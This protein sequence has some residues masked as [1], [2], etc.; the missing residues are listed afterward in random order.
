MSNVVKRAAI[1]AKQA[2]RD[3]KRKYTLEPY[4]HHPQAVAA[5][6]A[7]EGFDDGAVVAAWLHDVIEDCGVTR[8]T[9]RMIF[10]ERV[11][12]MVWA[13]TDQSK[14]EDGTRAERKAIDRAHIANASP[15]AK[16]IK[17]ADLIDNTRS[18][19]KH[20]P[21]FAKVY[22]AEIRLLMPSLADGN[23]R[24]YNIARLQV[25]AEAAA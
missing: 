23:R 13:V 15:E 5:L 18:I 8:E 12:S 9:I 3:Q 19:V 2:H 10:G 4:W 14:P 25:N 1:F 7:A 16:S 17:L 11:A 6:V 21:A 20:D 22:L 24:L